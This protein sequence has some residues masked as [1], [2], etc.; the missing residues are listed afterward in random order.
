[1]ANIFLRWITAG[2]NTERGLVGFLAKIFRAF[3]QATVPSGA[4]TIVVTDA[5]VKS[6]DI[7]LA[8]VQLFTTNACNVTKVTISAGVSFTITVNTDPGASGAV[9]AY[10][11][12]R[13]PNL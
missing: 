8:A 6:T 2:Q 9:I 11:R 4:T 7:I 1:M 5:D 10:V 13:N 3:G 12:L